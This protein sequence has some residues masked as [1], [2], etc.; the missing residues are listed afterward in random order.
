MMKKHAKP[1]DPAEFMTLE[2]ALAIVGCLADENDRL[3]TALVAI[4]A[5]DYIYRAA[6]LAREALAR[7]VGDA[8]AARCGASLRDDREPQASS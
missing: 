4:A 8:P 3:K 5:I 6:R 1:F 7:R 2:E